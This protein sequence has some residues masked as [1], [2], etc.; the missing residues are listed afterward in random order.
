M[1]RSRLRTHNTALLE[2]CEGVGAQIGQQASSIADRAMAQYRAS[3]PT[4]RSATNNKSAKSLI[5]FSQL[6]AAV[7]TA[8]VVI[9]RPRRVGTGRLSYQG[10]SRASSQSGQL[11]HLRRAMDT[12][13][14]KALL[15]SR[16]MA[17][18]KRDLLT[19]AKS[20]EM[21]K[22]VSNAFPRNNSSTL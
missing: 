7:F 19:T 18:L 21:L 16:R 4:I 22:T 6:P 10:T 14:S 20:P 15:T 12:R 2:S 11:S 5:S 9:K 13:L 8:Y 1:Q 17:T 3:R